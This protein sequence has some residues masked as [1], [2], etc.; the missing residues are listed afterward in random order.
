MKLCDSVFLVGSGEYGL[1]NL[2]DCSVYVV[3]TGDQLVMIDS[4]SGLESERII[5]NMIGDGLD[6]R[7][8][9]TVFL[10]HCHPDHSGGAHF[11]EKTYGARIFIATEEMELLLHGDEEQTGL[12]AAKR[13]GIYGPELSFVNCRKAS[14]ID[15]E[16]LFEFGKY[17]LKAIRVPGH[18]PGSMCFRIIGENLDALFTGDAVLADGVI[19]LLNIEGSTLK[20]FREFLPKLENETAKSLFPGHGVFTLSRGHE[21]IVRALEAVRSLAV[22]K[23]IL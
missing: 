1:S 22:P 13:Y 3:D 11:F 5:H 21:H 12:N 2:Y 20:G 23:S 18:S 15:D 7:K 19:G 16:M 6:V 14:S 17:S 8:L 9:K 10:T 4:G